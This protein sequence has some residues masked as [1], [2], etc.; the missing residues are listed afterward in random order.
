[1]AAASGVDTKMKQADWIFSMFKY[2]CW[3]V[4]DSDPSKHFEKIALDGVKAY[5][6]NRGRE[7]PKFTEWKKHIA[8]YQNRRATQGDE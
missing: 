3:A 8:K 4:T 7:T 5:R 2:W 1:M 6:L